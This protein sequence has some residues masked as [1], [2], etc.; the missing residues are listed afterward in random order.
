MATPAD[1]SGRVCDE[2]TSKR[3]EGGAVVRKLG[4]RRLHRQLRLAF[5][6]ERDLLDRVRALCLAQE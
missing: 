4:W 6:S 3:S 5:L 1:R 2:K